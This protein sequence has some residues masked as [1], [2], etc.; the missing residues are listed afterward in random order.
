MKKLLLL[1]IVFCLRGNAQIITTVAGNGY[2][3]GSEGGD[4][5]NGGLATNAELN[6]PYAVGVDAFGN[7]YIP[8]YALGYL[9]KVN[10]NGIITAF[11]GI[12][13]SA[14]S[15]DGGQA[16]AAG[17]GTAMAITTDIIGNVYFVE[18]DTGYYIR[19]IST[20]GTITTI[21]GNGSNVYSGDNGAATNA[22]LGYSLGIAIDNVG[23]LYISDITHHRIRM[24]NTNGI[25]STIAGTGTAGYTGDGGIAINAELNG[26]G[27][28]AIANSTSETSPSP[29]IY[30]T[31]MNNNRI[32]MI[33]AN[34]I[35][36]TVGGTG[37]A[38]YSGDGGNATSAMLKS[39]AGLCTDNNG[40]IYVA[41]NNNNRVRM[42][43]TNGMISTIAGNGIQGYTGDGGL[44][45][46]AEL[47]GA[48]GI[49]MNPDGNLFIADPWDNVIREIIGAAP[50]GIRTYNT[51]NADFSIYP[52]PTGLVIHVQVSGII[53]QS[54][55]IEVT[56]VLGNT[57][58]PHAAF[59]TPHSTLD[60][61]GLPPGIYFVHIGSSTQKFVKQ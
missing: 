25:I 4:T 5:G 57:V 36:S 34:G 46:N 16:T 49:A 30:F 9:R 35:I 27:G 38:G 14:H 50:A 15:G 61:S 17:I 24:I 31:D 32:R 8:D 44:A 43:T 33:S 2:D 51:L 37:T 10:T 54:T 60:V 21:G 11:A 6:E 28:I 40:N 20:N 26:P 13:I 52:N 39:P 47:Y 55:V 12:G 22:G 29:C 19:K 7:I 53:E 42:I 1:L 23:N 3:T 56:D 18:Q 58:I 48:V 59:N 45:I 41:D